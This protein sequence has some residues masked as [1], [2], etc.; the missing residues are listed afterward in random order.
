L[1][2]PESLHDYGPYQCGFIAAQVQVL[3]EI[4]DLA[5]DVQILTYSSFADFRGRSFLRPAKGDRPERDLSL[6][7][8]LVQAQQGHG[9]V[10]RIRRAGDGCQAGAGVSADRLGATEML[11]Q[12]IAPTLRR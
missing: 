4:D 1:R 10:P 11:L 5:Q 3:D 2:V 6:R 8:Q 7:S 12:C 9:A